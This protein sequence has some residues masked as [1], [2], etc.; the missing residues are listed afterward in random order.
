M[1][2]EEELLEILKP[3]IAMREEWFAYADDMP[4]YFTA[5]ESAQRIDYL[6]GATVAAYEFVIQ[7]SEGKSGIYFMEWHMR[8]KR[9]D[10]E[11]ISFYGPNMHFWKMSELIG[12]LCFEFKRTGQKM[13][14]SLHRELILKQLEMCR[15]MVNYSNEGDIWDRAFGAALGLIDLLDPEEDP[16]IMLTQLA[17]WECVRFKDDEDSIGEDSDDFR[18]PRFDYLKDGKEFLLTLFGV[19]VDAT[20]YREG[21]IPGGLNVSGSLVAIY[22][23]DLEEIITIRYQTSSGIFYREEGF[24]WNF[25]HDVGDF[26]DDLEMLYVKPEFVEHF[27]LDEKRG[28]RVTLDELTPYTMTYEEIFPND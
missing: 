9:A 13:R 26:F 15:L 27:D 6:L 28:R 5:Q 25:G 3:V 20:L 17:Q 16:S 18:Y 1:S 12:Q 10:S 2:N 7:K 11:L 4:K 22:D 21:D 8:Y 23:E 19:G 24:W 14:T